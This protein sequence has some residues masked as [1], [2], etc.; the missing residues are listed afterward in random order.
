MMNLGSLKAQEAVFGTEMK[1]VEKYN[2]LSYIYIS[3]LGVSPSLVSR[4][5]EVNFGPSLLKF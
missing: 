3:H 1:I 4:Y 2:L 5:Y